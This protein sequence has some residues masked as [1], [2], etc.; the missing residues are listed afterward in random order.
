MRQATFVGE[1]HQRHGA[2]DRQGEAEHG[3]QTVSVGRPSHRTARDRLPRGCTISMT[4]VI[5]VTS[6]TDPRCR[7]SANKTVPITPWIED[8]PD[9]WV[10]RADA[11]RSGGADSPGATATPV[12]ARPA[13]AAR[14]S[15]ERRPAHPKADQAD[16][17]RQ[18]DP[19]A[20]DDPLGD[21]VRP[22]PHSPHRREGQQHQ[23]DPEDGQRQPAPPTEALAADARDD[24]GHSRHLP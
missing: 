23:P 21:M 9:Q 4:K 5:A 15:D 18:H 8:R 1:P 13:A 12:Q 19:E 16:H 24:G 22:G 10:G 11:C 3:Q 6:V 17:D 2:A 14:T 7:A 20:Q